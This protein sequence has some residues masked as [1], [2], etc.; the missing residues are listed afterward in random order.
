[1][2]GRACRPTTRLPTL[3]WTSREDA[4]H[5]PTRVPNTAA[6]AIPNASRIRLREAAVGM[7]PFEMRS[8][9]AVHTVA[10]LGRFFDDTAPVADSSHHTPTTPARARTLG[11]IW[12][13]AVLA[14]L[15]GFAGFP[16][17]NLPHL[18]VELVVDVTDDARHECV[19]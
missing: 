8:H 15:G 3:R 5:T 10:G 6:T 13:L 11:Q 17:D 16:S 12:L 14:R 7:E 4:I 19:L 1:M 18:L 9:S 2:G